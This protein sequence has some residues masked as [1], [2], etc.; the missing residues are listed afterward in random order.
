MHIYGSSETRFKVITSPL[1]P[2]N[3]LAKGEDC[4]GVDLIYLPEVTFDVDKFIKD[5]GNL[6]KEERSVVIAVSEGVKI[7]DGRYVCA[8]ILS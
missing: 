6:L 7:A 1:L 2:S 8:K 4:E 3:A 5:V